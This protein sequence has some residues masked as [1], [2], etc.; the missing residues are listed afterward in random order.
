MPTV[1]HV[2][3]RQVIKGILCKPLTLQ[4]LQQE[5]EI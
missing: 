1:A 5:T 2:H 4:T 3:G